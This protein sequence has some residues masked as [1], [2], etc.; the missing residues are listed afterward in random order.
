MYKKLPNTLFQHA[1]SKFAVPS[2]YCNDG[3]LIFTSE[4]KAKD[5]KE[6]D[7]HSFDGELMAAPSKAY[8]K[9]S[10][11]KLITLLLEKQGKASGAGKPYTVIFDLT[12]DKEKGVSYAAV[13]TFNELLNLVEENEDFCW[14]QSEDYKSEDFLGILDLYKFQ[15]ELTSILDEH[16]KTDFDQQIINEIVLWKV[17]RYVATKSENNWLSLLNTFKDDKELDFDKLRHFLEMVLPDKIR[18]IRLAMASTFLRFRNPK[19]FQIIDER[20]FRIIMKGKNEQTKLISY[21]KTE[22][23]IDLYIRYLKKLKKFCDDKN[24]SFEDSD[25]ILYQFD[26]IK[27]GDF[28]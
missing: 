19:I 6:T 20:T 2:G 9:I 4:A 21:T 15:P 13:Y 16:N 12:V 14:G 28:N 25:R 1:H 8:R 3:L 18:G 10:K 26:I 23:Q 17:N 24:I 22:D 5:Y 27:N 7:E 11:N